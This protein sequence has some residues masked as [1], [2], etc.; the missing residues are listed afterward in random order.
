MKSDE[1]K[2]DIC[3]N[4]EWPRLELLC[5]KSAIEIGLGLGLKNNVFLKHI[6]RNARERYNKSGENWA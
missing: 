4:W 5:P 1:C 6:N 2:K 3:Q